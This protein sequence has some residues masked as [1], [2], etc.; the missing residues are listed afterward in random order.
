MLHH[1][2]EGKTLLHDIEVLEK[3]LDH[4]YIFNKCFRVFVEEDSEMSAEVKYIVSECMFGVEQRVLMRLKGLLENLQT[5][6]YRFLSGDE[7]VSEGGNFY[8]V[9][10]NGMLPTQKKE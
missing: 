2:Y 10:K 7:L 9:G 8:V 4:T 6:G 5:L 3:L 1:K